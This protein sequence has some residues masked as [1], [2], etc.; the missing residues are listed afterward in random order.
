MKTIFFIIFITAVMSLA[1][2]Y[3]TLENY[4]VNQWNCAI[5]NEGMNYDEVKKLLGTPILERMKSDKV[6]GDVLYLG[7]NSG[8]YGI[9]IYLKNKKVY[10]KKCVNL[11][12]YNF[13]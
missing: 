2:C 6:Q 9:D 1:G 10:M 13:D 3:K 12:L 8:Y 4:K 7:Y 11:S 5:I